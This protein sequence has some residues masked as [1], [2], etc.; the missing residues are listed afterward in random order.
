MA[1]GAFKRSPWELPGWGDCG[2]GEELVT[3]R[4]EELV[5]GSALHE[6]CL[7]GLNSGIFWGGVRIEIWEEPGEEVKR[8][9]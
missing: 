3:G 2:F 7:A 6:W 4:W 9:R 5:V 8:L 1:E